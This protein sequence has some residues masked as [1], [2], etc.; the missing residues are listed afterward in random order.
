MATPDLAQHRTAGADTATQPASA[1][2]RLPGIRH[3]IAIGSGKGG[4]GKSTVSVNLALALRQRGAR[5]GLVDADIH[6]PSVPVMLGLPTGEPPAMT[7]EERI[8]PATR[9]GLK[10]ISMAMLT[11]DDNPAIL[12]GPMVSKYLRLFV[13]SVDWGRLDYLLLDLPPGTGDTQ[14]TLAQSFPLS[15]A[16]IVTTPQEVSLRI[17]RR[18]L[19]MFETVHVP[20][21]G[22]VENMSTF[23]CPHCGGATDIFR[24]GGGAL[25]SQALGVPFLGAIPLD[26]K[27]VECGD[28]GRPIV[29]DR[30]ESAAALAYVAIAA[31]LERALE[32]LPAAGLQ[33]FEWAWEKNEGGPAWLES[34]A[35]LAGGH[36]TAIGLR[37]RDPRTLSVLWEDGGRSD[38]D[39]RDLR[40]A[41]RC[42]FCVEE[43]SGR[44]LLDPKKVRADVAPLKIKSV[45]N[46][47]VAITW[48]DGHS[49][50]IY[51]FDYLRA[52][53]DGNRAGEAEDV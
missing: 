31:Q 34:A 18:G 1:A 4:V 41:C 48:N 24:R 7:A 13:G 40:L 8:V 25:L 44:A 33:P 47:A 23:T 49:T 51:A 9:H 36:T 35:R 22:I 26:G 12:R 27:V 53:A 37:R 11:G 30:P 21:L 10:L 32:R 17:A 45:G 19:R 50:G 42:A 20:V 14:L 2:D 16:I 39:V 29:S 43:T 52:F 28:E 6:G 15:G 38:F 5:V 46:Y 3:I